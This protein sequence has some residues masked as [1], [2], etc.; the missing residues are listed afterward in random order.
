MSQLTLMGVGLTGPVVAAGG[1][2]AGS[3]ILMETGSY[4]LLETGDKFIIE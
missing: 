2:G 4:L 1:G 3:F